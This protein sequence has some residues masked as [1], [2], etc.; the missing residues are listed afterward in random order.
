MGRAGSGCTTSG[1]ARVSATVAVWRPATATMSPATAR[2]TGTRLRPRKASRRVVRARS[3]T[4]FPGRSAWTARLAPIPPL[5]MRPVRTRPRKGSDSRMAAAMAKGPSGAARGAGTCSSIVS[6]SGPSP[7][8]GP[9]GAAA[10]QPSLADAN[11][12]GKS[13]WRSSASRAAKRSKVS[14]CTSKGRASG[15]ST[16]FTTTMGAS[17]AASALVSTNFVCGIGPSEAST[18]SRQPSTMP[19]TRSTSPPK[20]AWPGVSTML[21]RTAPHSTEVHLARMV[22]PRSRSSALESRAR[23]ATRW[24]ERKAPLWRSSP[25]TSVVLPWSTWAMMAILRRSVMVK[26][27]HQR[28]P[29]AAAASGRA[30]IVR[31]TTDL[32]GFAPSLRRYVPMPPPSCPDLFRASPSTASAGRPHGWPEQVRP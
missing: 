28:T 6:N 21:M 1:A 23:S 5:S 17:P 2:S 16:L 3:T 32:R 31:L 15:L 24:F 14:S 26:N 7:S 20:S 9:S 22:M 25:S 30:H 12:V 18:S 13:S 10:A 4:P 27:A 19:S 11:R 8:R 29:Q